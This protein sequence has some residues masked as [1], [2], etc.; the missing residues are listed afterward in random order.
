M[1]LAPLLRST[2]SR[3]SSRIERWVPG[4]QRLC[5]IGRTQ[6]VAPAS[7]TVVSWRATGTMVRGAIVAQAT[8]LSSRMKP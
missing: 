2:C 5:T 6:S 7:P 1:P 8:V 4:Y 3:A